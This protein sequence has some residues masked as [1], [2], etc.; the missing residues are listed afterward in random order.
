MW[1]EQTFCDAISGEPTAGTVRGE[2]VYVHWTFEASSWARVGST[3][4]WSLVS[5]S[6]GGVAVVLPVSDAD[7]SCEG[8][9]LRR[10]SEMPCSVRLETV[11]L[12]SLGGVRAMGAIVAALY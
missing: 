11:S 6:G 8:A 7:L 9:F 5:G 10:A 4:C 3:G 2:V 1:S 12:L